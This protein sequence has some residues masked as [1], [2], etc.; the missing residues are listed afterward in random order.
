MTNLLTTAELAARWRM[1]RSTLSNWRCAGTGPSWI[2]LGG[3]KSA[4]VLYRLADIKA[5]EKNLKA[6]A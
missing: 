3:G 2:K 5:Y 6:G 4:R 1:K